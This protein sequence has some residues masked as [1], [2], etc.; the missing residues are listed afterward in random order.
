[1]AINNSLSNKCVCN[2]KS[3][4]DKNLNANAISKNPKVTLTEFNQPP[5]CGSEFNQPGKAANNANGNAIASENPN[6]PI[7]GPL[8]PPVAASTSKVP[9][10]GPVQEKETNASVN[11][12]KNIPINPPLPSAFT[13]L[14]VHEEGNCI[15]NA[16]KNDAPKINNNK[17]N[18]ML[19][20]Y[21][22][23][24]TI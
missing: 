12:M 9:T 19:K 5:D 23:S 1:M 15:S 22:G 14:S 17:K 7:M 18:P 21:I 3:A 6:I 20:I 4:L 10:I 13:L 16:P 8:T 11:A 2:T 24:H